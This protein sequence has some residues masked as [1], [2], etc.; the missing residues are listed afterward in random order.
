MKIGR[1]LGWVTVRTKGAWQREP[2]RLEYVWEWHGGR[3]SALWSR[4][5]LDLETQYV[6][7]LELNT[8]SKF[9]EGL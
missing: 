3:K 9:I 1:S 4:E 5:L 2:E 8:G 7:G 6:R